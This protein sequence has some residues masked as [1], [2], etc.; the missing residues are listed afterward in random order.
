V[1]RMVIAS[2]LNSSEALAY[3]QDIKLGHYMKVPPCVIRSQY[4]FVELTC[5]GGSCSG[6]RSSRLHS[7]ARYNLVYSPGM[8]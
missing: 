4:V 6:A 2:M 5:E 3:T 7:P 1:K 8:R